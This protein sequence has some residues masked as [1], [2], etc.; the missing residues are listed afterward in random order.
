MR[1]DLTYVFNSVVGL[2]AVSEA[3]M[4]IR[5]CDAKILKEARIF[6]IVFLLTGP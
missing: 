3:G 4:Q 1:D 5:T 2:S 6:I